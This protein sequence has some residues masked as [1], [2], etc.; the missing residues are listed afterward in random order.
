M[1]D[2]RIDPRGLRSYVKSEN[3]LSFRNDAKVTISFSSRQFKIAN[4][5]L[6]D[7]ALMDKE[8]QFIQ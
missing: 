2:M 6:I 7:F 4:L 1:I 8:S 5:F 3:R